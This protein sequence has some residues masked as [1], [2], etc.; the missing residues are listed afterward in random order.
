ML[1]L[2][3]GCIPTVPSPGYTPKD[4]IGKIETPKECCDTSKAHMSGWV[5]MVGATVILTD[6]S[7]KVTHTTTT[8]AEGKYQFTNVDPGLYIIT[9]ICPLNEEYLIKDVVDKLAGDALNAGITDCQSTA[10]ALVVEYLLDIYDEDN[11]CFGEGTDVYEQVKR[12]A[13]EYESLNLEGIDLASIKAIKPEFDADLVDLVCY[14]LE[15]CCTAPEPGFTPE[16][17]GGTPPPYDP[18]PGPGPGPSGVVLLRIEF[19]PQA[20]TICMGDTQ[21]I[22]SLK[23]FYSDGSKINLLG[24]PSLI[25]TSTNGHATFNKNNGEVTGVSVG[26]T[27]FTATFGGKSDILDVTV[28]HPTADAGGPYTGEACSGGTVTINLNGSSSTAG[29]AAIATYDWNFGDGSL[30]AY[31]VGPTPSHDYAPGS[32]TATLTVTDSNGCTDTDTATVNITELI[33]PTAEAGGPYEGSAL[34]IVTITFAGSATAGGAAIATYDWNFGDGSTGTGVAPSHDYD[35]G[36]YTVTLTVTDENGCTGTDIATVT[37]HQ[38]T[39][40]SAHFMVA[41]EDLPIE[42]GNDWDYNDFVGE[43]SITYHLWSPDKLEEIDFTSIIH[44]AR[45]AGHSHELHVIIDG[46]DGGHTYTTSSGIYGPPI[47]NDFH[48]FNPTDSTVGS[49]YDLTINFDD[50]PVPFVNLAIDWAKIH[51]DNDLPFEFYLYDAESGGD[52]KVENG[53]IRKLVVPDTWTIPASTVA[54]WTVYANV[55]P[56]PEFS[57]EDGTWELTTP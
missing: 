9:A 7:G 32:Y 31:N 8:E 44:K 26:S 21:S 14:C 28:T 41:F 57:G 27:T 18:G 39:T 30:I 42:D 49:T 3:N 20:M 1:I 15:S 54:I 52:S 19:D 47:V 24:N 4:I 29:G 23:A 46:Y 56:G 35:P 17:S 53:D 38:K 43:I 55:D 40:Q 5:P 12:V 36:S 34:T 6:D 13:A 16:P 50:K 22:N 11:E 10:L 51:G 25:V 48:L 2:L 33:G 45:S 37:I